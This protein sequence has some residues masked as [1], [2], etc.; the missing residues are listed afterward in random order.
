MGYGTRAALSKCPVRLDTSVMNFRN[1]C[2]SALQKIVTKLMERSPLKYPLT[3]ALTCLN[4]Q[5]MA[6]GGTEKEM[7]T[8]LDILLENNLFHP[9]DCEKVDREYRHLV[10]S[11]TL[12][13][14]IKTY[15]LIETRLDEFWYD[16]IGKKKEYECLFKVV[17]LFLSLSHG[18][19]NIERGFSV[20]KEILVENLHQNSLIAQRLIYDSVTNVGG[21]EKIKKLTKVCYMQ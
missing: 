10:S 9:S 20:N 18:N 5:H 11:P 15:S 3:K 1:S 16:V 14:Q 13:S 17:K 12:T 19:A 21:I 6:K 2:R 7:R 8:C 4:P